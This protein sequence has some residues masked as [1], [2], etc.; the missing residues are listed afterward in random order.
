[1]EKKK[2]S[3]NL[4][5]PPCIEQEVFLN[6]FN[7][8]KVGGKARYFAR[9]SRSEDLLQVIDFINENRLNFFILGAGSNVLFEDKYFDGIVVNILFKGISVIKESAEKILVKAFSGESWDGF[10]DFCTQKKFFGL[11]NLTSIPGSVG[12]AVVQNIG[13]YGVEISDKIFEVIVVNIKN[14]NK[15]I[16]K[17]KD[18]GFDYRHSIF[19]KKAFR[20]YVIV[21]VVFEL[22][23]KSKAVIDYKDLKDYFSINKSKKIN[24]NNVRLALKGIRANKFP[25]LKKIGT[26]GSFFKNVVLTKKQAKVFLHRFPNTPFFEFGNKIKIP[27]GFIL[28][29]V[30][31]LKGYREGNVGLFENQSLVLVNFGNASAKEIFSFKEKIKKI[32]FKKTG[33]KI[34]EEVVLIK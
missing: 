1:M 4:V 11:E 19:K 12:G 13:A 21:E 8:F 2:K 7:T 34:E 23:K 28:D 31:N 25:D 16:I 33:I 15:K 29:K 18:L 5:M 17:N 6:K 14:G 30:C 24:H 22:N 9:V 10:V 27:T 26:A 3:E 32:V 20:D